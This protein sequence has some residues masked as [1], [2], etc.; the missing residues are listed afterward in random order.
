MFNGF[1]NIC[2]YLMAGMCESK[3]KKIEKKRLTV[4]LWQFYLFMLRTGQNFASFPT[5]MGCHFCSFLMGAV[6]LQIQE[7]KIVGYICVY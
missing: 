3:R 1:S 6:K 7:A 2:Y 4:L 5:S